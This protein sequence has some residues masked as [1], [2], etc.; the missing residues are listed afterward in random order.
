LVVVGP[1]ISVGRG[2]AGYN[3]PD[4]DQQQCYYHAPTVKPEV[5]TAIVEILLIGVETP[6]TY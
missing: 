1:V 3:Q 6:E 4:H 5:V 2:R